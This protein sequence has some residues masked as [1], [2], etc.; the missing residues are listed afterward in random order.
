M[1][2][3]DSD[4]K[5]DFMIEK[6]K[7][8]PLNKRKLIR[9]TLITALMAV[10]FGL[11]ACFTFLIL[12]PLISSR[13]YPAEELPMVVFPEDPVELAPEDMLIE[14]VPIELPT[15]DQMEEGVVLEESQ[16]QEILSGVE[17]NLENYKQLYQSVASYIRQLNCYMTTVTAISSN[18]DWLQNT[19]ENRNQ[20]SG[21]IIANNTREL[22]I[23]TD[24]T[25]L[26]QADRLVVTFANDMQ[27][28]AQLKGVD[29]NT[30]LA[31]LGVTLEVIPQDFIENGLAIAS[32]GSSN[33]K[34]L[35]G[36]SVIAMGS[37]MGNVG[38]VGYGIITSSNTQ[39]YTVDAN[40]KFLQTD[41]V[42]S[43]KAGGVLF[44]L[45]G[46]VIGIITTNKT[47]VDV[48]TVIG[49]Y[50][51]TDMKKRIENLSNE[52]PFAYLGIT[53]SEVSWDVHNELQIPYGAYVNDV[54]INS[55]AMLAGIQKGDVITEIA[56]RSISSFGE[57]SN[58]LTQLTPGEEIL[59]TIVRQVQGEY[60]SVELNI[61]LG[62]IE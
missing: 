27:V 49:A 17:L 19:K 41:I 28:E 62:E 7:E 26:R 14:D 58:I 38:S 42:G 43:Q 48:K 53:G 34:N 30:N 37:P 40:F 45:Q 15:V 36:T 52:K 29:T 47:G 57:Y 46:E 6:I 4:L 55:P 16:I 50:G 22:L 44:N 1:P 35:E 5:N 25:P 39:M 51:I 20:A 18:T 56:G 60:K 3:M 11:V 13:L 8:R 10:I 2:D 9:R 23:L 31:V 21:L 33:Y 59:L 24:Y 61:T 32:L 12:E 54:A